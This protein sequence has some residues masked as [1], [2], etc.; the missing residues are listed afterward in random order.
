[1]SQAIKAIIWRLSGFSTAGFYYTFYYN[2]TRV[3]SNCLEN[4]ALLSDYELL[5]WSDVRV[6]VLADVCLI[7]EWNSYLIKN[8]ENKEIG[9]FLPKR[10]II[11]LSCDLNVLHFL[12]RL[13]IKLL[14]Q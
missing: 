9:H 1:M 12:L 6:K 7:W 8:K 4:L 14:C 2:C 5:R 10:L 11:F 3:K 13:R